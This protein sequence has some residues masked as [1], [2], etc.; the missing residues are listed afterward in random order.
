LSAE[1]T[2][3]AIETYRP[4]LDDLA[5][6]PAGDLLSLRNGSRVLVA[7]V[8]VATQTPPTRSGRRVVFITVDDGTGCAECMFFEPAQSRSGSVLFGTSVLLVAGRTRRTGERG[9]AI[10]AEAAWDL[11]QRW[12]TH[13][14][15]PSSISGVEEAV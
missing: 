3:H 15:A 4:M 11:K 5:V 14:L 9:I 1:L 6:T 7:G 13:L 2:E 8:R 10:H 12:A